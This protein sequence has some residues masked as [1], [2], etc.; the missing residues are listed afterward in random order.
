MIVL[1]VIILLLLVIIS[2]Q[3]SPNLEIDIVDGVGP[4][5]K[6]EIGGQSV[7]CLLD[8]GSIYLMSSISSKSHLEKIDQVYYYA[9]PSA[10]FHWDY[11]RISL[12]ESSQKLCI[13]NVPVGYVG[14]PKSQK[15]LGLPAVLGLCALPK[16]D[17]QRFQKESL[18]NN[19]QV[20]EFWFF[21]SQTRKTFLMDSF[22]N[23]KPLI[24]EIYID[25]QLSQMGLGYLTKSITHLSVKFTDKNSVDYS[26]SKTDR[27]FEYSLN[28]N[29]YNLEI[30]EWVCLFDTG[31]YPA[32]FFS[33]AE[34]NLLGPNVAK[35]IL[36]GQMDPSKYKKADVTFVFQE[37]KIIKSYNVS[38]PPI[39]PDSFEK[40]DVDKLMTV[41]GFQSHDKKD[42]RYRSKNKLPYSVSFY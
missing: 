20:N 29:V 28:K 6:L 32:V 40:D 15:A 18:I 27:G 22:K 31:T 9:G 21:L 38:V 11:A 39:L 33:N 36:K 17:T 7:K 8:T 35:S 14:D 2:R 5:I 12:G 13:N 1:F 10:T 41:F 34:T 19:L 30:S 3:N 25:P 4:M 37:Y 23:P 24:H 16:K 42:V 26:I